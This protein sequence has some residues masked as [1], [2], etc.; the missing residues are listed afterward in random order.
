MHDPL[1][2][3]DGL[4]DPAPSTAVA[5]I[6]DPVAL[7]SDKAIKKRKGLHWLSR[8]V[9]WRLAVMAVLLWAVALALSR[10]PAGEASNLEARTFAFSRLA[11]SVVLAFDQRGEVPEQFHAF[12]GIDDASIRDEVIR[13]YDQ[14]VAANRIPPGVLS[15]WAILLDRI[16]DSERSARAL[17]ALLL[18]EAAEDVRQQ[19]ELTGVLLAYREGG[20][21]QLSERTEV[22]LDQRIAEET[23]ELPEWLYVAEV[24]GDEPTREWLAGRGRNILWRGL[25]ADLGYLLMFATGVAAIVVIWIRRPSGRMDRP[26]ALPDRWATAALTSWF[27]YAEVLAL[28]AALVAAL[29]VLVPGAETVATVLCAFVFVG[30]PIWI[31]MN[32]FF[33]GSSAMFRVMGLRPLPFPAARL[34]LFTFA[35]VG[36][37]LVLAGLS[38]W[39][40]TPFAS[41]MIEDTLTP[42][43][44]DWPGAIWSE[45]FIAV[46]LAPVGEEILFR[47]LLYGGLSRKMHAL[48]AMVI[49][50]LVFAVSHQY[51]ISGLVFVFLYG[52]VFCWLYKRTGSLWPGILAHGLY[53]GLITW[54][55]VAWFSFHG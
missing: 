15:E 48:W 26:S 33:P 8:P 36:V 31:M 21:G 7:A 4:K 55:G 28:I 51:A 10:F 29:L 32:R 12:L 6:L 9:S 24:R 3:D 54:Q 46:V 38:A 13:I 20:D 50:S 52:L 53:N 14:A 44:L 45:A 11:S 43:G 39:I 18:A 17:E 49:S 41:E 1:S 16:G 40:L 23:W 35:G 47:G 34:V 19:E 25:A 5:P 2:P 37:L 27:F 30:V 22:W 42:T